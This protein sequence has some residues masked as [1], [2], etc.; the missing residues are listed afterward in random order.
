[1]LD[2]R[3][4]AVSPRIG[5]ACARSIQASHDGR[6]VAYLWSERG[7]DNLSLWVTEVAAGKSQCVLPAEMGYR[8]IEELPAEVELLRERMRQ[9][10]F[11]VI[12]FA[13]F[14]N[15]AS[16]LVP[17]GTDLIVV[18]VESAQHR[19]VASASGPIQ[20][21]KISP[22]GTK[23]AFTCRNDLW[24]A[25]GLDG[26]AVRLRPLT[27]GGNDRLLNGVADFLVQEELSRYD[28]FWWHPQSNEIAFVQTDLSRVP[29]VGLPRRFV[30]AN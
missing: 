4:I 18:D 9:R 19:S 23:V 14:P 6:Y 3:S 24:L 15:R 11:G 22:D 28:A 2:D 21:A 1:M 12:G 26:G 20:V 25:E 5:T 17:R 10:Y 7:D 8:S 16:L 13:W 29:I 27:T 30:L